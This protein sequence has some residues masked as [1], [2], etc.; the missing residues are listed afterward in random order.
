MAA[1]SKHIIHSSEIMVIRTALQ[2]YQDMDDVAHNMLK[3]FAAK[4]GDYD[5]RSF[6]RRALN[7]LDAVEKDGGIE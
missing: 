6:A 5:P 4:P 7:V 3:G 2:H 1:M